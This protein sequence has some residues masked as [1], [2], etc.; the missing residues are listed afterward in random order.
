MYTFNGLR[1]KDEV[2]IVRPAS[3]IDSFS[4]IAT[5]LYDANPEV[6]SAWFNGNRQ[7]GI[8][9]LTYLCSRNRSFFSYE[10]LVVVEERQSG[11]IVGVANL[12]DKTVRLDYDYSFMQE[13]DQNANDVIDSYIYE[14]IDTV[15][16]TKNRRTLFIPNLCG[17]NSQRATSIPANQ[18]MNAVAHW[19]RITGY[20][21]IKTECLRGDSSAR[22][23]YR[24]H[25]FTRLRK[26]D[27]TLTRDGE[28]IHTFIY[29]Y[30][31]KV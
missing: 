23:F 19:A 24:S 28:P 29:A 30:R 1:A 20:D 14:W 13:Y 27:R 26:N 9:T 5:I 11:Q 7:R 22:D 31:Y 17:R 15:C 6:F 4:Q 12:L 16:G 18:L 10:H 2:Y 3:S 8:N 21:V 25:G